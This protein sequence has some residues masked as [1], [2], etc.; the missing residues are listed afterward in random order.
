[1]P[2]EIKGYVH[3]PQMPDHLRHRGDAIE[4]HKAPALIRLFAWLLFLRS[5]INLV[6][7]LIVGFAPDTVV[8]NYVAQQFDVYPKQIPP[9]A[10]FFIFA[11]LYGFI[12]WRWYTRDWRA[13]WV[14]MF[15]SG[16]TAVKMM[17][18]FAADHAVGNP[19]P[20]TD[21]QKSALML[22][23]VV[24]LLISGYL[25]FYPGMEQAFKETP[26]E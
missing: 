7:A 20:M 23:I 14:A 10:M 15:M 16:A 6:F 17:V 2:P 25:A 19:T 24:N 11:F 8:A 26:W 22:S 12:G 13:R 5:G 18:N 1:M 21:T 4:R 3:P 9:E